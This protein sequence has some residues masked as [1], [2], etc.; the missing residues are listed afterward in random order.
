M[1]S[2]AIYFILNRE[3]DWKDE[4]II[5]NLEFE[6]DN[7][8][9]KSRSGENGV[10]ISKPFDSLQRGTKW[11][12]LRLNINLPSGASYKLKIYASDTPE[13]VVP[14]VSV[15][16]RGKSKVD[17][18]EYIKDDS[19]DIGRKIDTFDLIGAKVFDN[20]RDI[21]LYDFKGRYLWICL[22]II[23]YVDEPVIINSVKIEFPQVTFVDYLPEVYRKGAGENSFLSRF[24][25]IFQSIYVDLEDQIDSIP[26]KFDP[27]HTTKDFLNW[28]A[29][30]LSIK[31]PS[32]WGEKRLRKLVKESV[33]IYKMKGTRRAISKVVEEYIGVEPIIVEQFDVKDNMCYYKQKAL[34]ENLFGDNGY[35]FTVMLPESCVKDTESY[36][37]LLRVINTVK[38]VDSVCNL[39]VLNDQIYL[40]NHC[41]MGINSFITKTQGLV[42]NKTQ[43]DINNLV[44]SGEM[45]KNYKE[46]FSDTF[47]EE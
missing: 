2:G 38:P 12:R 32:M 26:L 46:Y 43:R 44:I 47:K 13:I 17:I 28:M 8:V 9:F 14:S 24:L 23:S 18:N 45:D 31:D 29:E 35:I 16:V 25:G 19:I 36:I 11:H 15:G 4:S 41:Y 39:V 5:K 3:S 27:D 40:D 33:N 42:L 30:W 34:I 37:E 22:E 20:P 6:N 7:L 10:Y 21:L 1:A